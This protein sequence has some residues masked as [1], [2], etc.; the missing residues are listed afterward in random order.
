[1]DGARACFD[2]ETLVRP[3]ADRREPHEILA[4]FYVAAMVRRGEPAAGEAKWER[5]P[6]STVT[7]DDQQAAMVAAG[8]E[9]WARPLECR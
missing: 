8:R 6:A 4:E 5:L 9:A 7:P 3:T 2:H 1:V